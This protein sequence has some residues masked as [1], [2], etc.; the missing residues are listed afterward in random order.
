MF[1]G[2]PTR[3]VCAYDTAAL[4][5]LRD[6]LSDEAARL[7]LPRERTLPFVLAANEVATGIVRDGGGRGALWVWAEG[8]ELICDVTDPVGALTERFPGYE[9][10]GAKGHDPA[11][12]AV[13]RLCHIVEPRST[14]HGLQVR[15]RLKLT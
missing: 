4:P 10:P 6:F 7:G 5:E 8:G 11:M 15:L 1:A 12:W 9:P 13:R 3:I 2:T 14:P